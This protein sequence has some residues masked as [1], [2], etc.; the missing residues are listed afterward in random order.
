MPY[1]KTTFTKPIK[2]DGIYTIH[3]F[4]YTKDFSYSG[5]FH[6]FWE[7]V[8]ADKKSVLIT[9]GATEMLLKAGQMFI[10]R[11]NEFHKIRCDGTRAANAVIL[12]FD[13]DCDELYSAAGKI[14]TCSTEEKQLLGTIVSEAA[15]AF[16]TPLGSPY[17]TVMKKSDSRKF[18]CEQTI[19]TCIEL[20]L[21]SLIR[22]NS[23]KSPDTKEVNNTL[24]LEICEY[25]E[26]NVDKALKFEDIRK[27]FN[28]SASVIK[29][30]FKSA[31]NCGIMEH[32]MRLKIDNA[33]Q[34]I[35]ENE[36]NFT[37][38]SEHLCFS[39]PQYFSSAFTR[40]CGMT[41]REYANSVKANFE[42]QNNT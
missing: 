28:V 5:E 37:E 33:K 38:I 24:L 6:D 13:C 1:E 31:L 41:P 3:Y 7:I 12:S 14:I 35:R 22:R 30:L 17:T 21:I 23:A 34:L 4:E 20:L 42:N 29:R 15:E 10:H 18:A 27:H 39:S 19:G 11:P 25:L 36:M 40:V 26:A 2:I 8:Y 9:A 32:F 16:D